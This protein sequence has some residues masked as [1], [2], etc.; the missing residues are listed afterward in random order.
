[1]GNIADDLSAD[2]K[3][4]NTIDRDKLTQ[5]LARLIVLSAQ[6]QTA[7][8]VL[9]TSI[10]FQQMQ[11]A[12]PPEDA[13]SFITDLSAIVTDY[14]NGIAD[15]LSEAIVDNISN[16]YVLEE[17]GLSL[18]ALNTMINEILK[19]N[20]FSSV[21]PNIFYTYNN[22]NLRN[23]E[24]LH[25]NPNVLQNSRPLF[26]LAVEV[27]EKHLPQDPFT[28]G[29][30]TIS[31]PEILNIDKNPS[32]ATTSLQEKVEEIKSK[33]TLDNE[34][35]TVILTELAL[36]ISPFAKIASH[37]TPPMQDT[38][39]NIYVRLVTACFGVIARLY[40]AEL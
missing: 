29:N 12:L 2:L 38:F 13:Q 33:Y 17:K 35:M 36:R 27:L 28:V 39:G 4:E 40:A 19:V 11:T 30:V 24:T 25:N 18:E 8:D 9:D 32:N 20:Q 26:A 6:Q 1:M 14:I 22:G 7:P 37:A 21:T 34:R 31:I 16:T 23:P 15:V 3:A 10:Y 5:A